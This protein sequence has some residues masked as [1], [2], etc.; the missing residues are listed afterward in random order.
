MA[1]VTRRQCLR[2]QLGRERASRG[3]A[4]LS[5]PVAAMPLL[6]R[7]W[8]RLPAS[9]E[10][11]AVLPP[12]LLERRT[13]RDAQNPFELPRDEFIAHFRVSQELVMDVVNILRQ[14]LQKE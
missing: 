7:P 8:R 11:R 10:G 6:R 4:M 3:G 12:P 1:F 5:P 9:R 13:L 2:R 14:D